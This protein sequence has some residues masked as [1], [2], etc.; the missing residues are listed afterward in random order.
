MKKID[1][2]LTKEIVKELNAGDEVLLNGWLFTARDKA[3]QKLSISLKKKE[4][5]PIDLKD[6]IIYYTGPTPTKPGEVIGSAG[7]TTSSR[8]DV[9]TPI[10]LEHGVIATIGKGKRS[11]EVISAIKK[12]NCLYFV[13]IGGAG[14]WLAQKIIQA[15]V[16]A[17]HSLGPE[18]IF[19]LCV[20]NFPVI[21][22]VDSQ[23]NSLN[24]IY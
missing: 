5:L 20:K 9:F 2:P 15:E 7:P 23:G 21:V 19:K 1:L 24:L 17:Y 11:K 14:A 16:I 13:T 4:N 12:Y 8:M 18:A 22:A 10:L 3:H 6:I